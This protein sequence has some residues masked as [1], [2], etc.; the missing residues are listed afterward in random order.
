M[1]DDAMPE[2]YSNGEEIQRGDRVESIWDSIPLDW[3]IEVVM[4]EAEVVVSREPSALEWTMVRIL[5]EF[6]DQPPTLAEAAEELG[7]KDPVFLAETLNRLEGSGIVERQGPG[8]DLDLAGCRLTEAGHAFLGQGRLN[9]IPERHGLRLYLDMITGEHIRQPPRRTRQESKNA[10]IAVDALPAR[11]TTLGLDR[12]RELAK[13]QDEPFLTAGSKIA[14]V[15]VQPDQ[16]SVLWRRYDVTVGIDSTGTVRAQLLRGTEQQQQW[17]AQLDLRHDGFEKLF[18]SSAR[19][20]Y[21]HLLPAAKP[22]ADWRPSVERLVNPV[23]VVQEACDL[24]RSAQQEVVTHVYW[25]T[26]PEVRNELSLARA[27]GIRDIAFAHQSQATEV[28]VTLSNMAG[29]LYGGAP[30]TY[31]QAA[32]LA[33]GSRGLSID[34][35]QVRSPGN[36]ELDVIVASSLTSSR[37]R[38]LRQELPATAGGE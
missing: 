20:P 37:A 9:S 18:S 22:Y 10:I 12:A 4:T 35:V 30:G 5:Q 2:T 33:D 19:Q 15:T 34:R 3:P 11:R 32:L 24:I 7:I 28:T 23:R 13:D 31:G 21:V 26:L 36:R 17:L 27:R 8:T 6:A 38:Q 14:G 1:E 25:P 16:G 29:V